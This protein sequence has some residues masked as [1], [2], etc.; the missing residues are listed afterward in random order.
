MVEVRLNVKPDAAFVGDAAKVLV[1]SA[2][3][4]TVLAVPRDALILR[5]DN[6]YLFKLDKENTAQRIAVGTGAEDGS[7]V[8]VSGTLREGERIII[9]GAEHLESGQKVRLDTASAAGGGGSIEQV[10]NPG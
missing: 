8:E 4:R 2:E 9:R 1:P 3:P 5:E 7:M 6:T 10:A